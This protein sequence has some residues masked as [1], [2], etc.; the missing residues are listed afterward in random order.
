MHGLVLFGIVI[1]LAMLAWLEHENAKRHDEVMNM[2]YKDV[3]KTDTKTNSSDF[4]MYGIATV[5]AV[6]VLGGAYMY[7][8]MY[9]RRMVY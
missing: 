1:V 7:C 8:N 5:I 6:V 2:I 9:P 4:G 3:V